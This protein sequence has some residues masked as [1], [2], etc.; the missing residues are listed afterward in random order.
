[1]QWRVSRRIS[2]HVLHRL[3]T[4]DHDSLPHSKHP[5]DGKTHAAQATL[6]PGRH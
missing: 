1:M 6:L 2:Q 5:D 3:S 4:L